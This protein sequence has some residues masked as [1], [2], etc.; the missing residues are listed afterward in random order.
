MCFKIGDKIRLRTIEEMKEA[1]ESKGLWA[2]PSYLNHFGK[3]GVI[4]EDLTY[5]YGKPIYKVKFSE[6]KEAVV[7]SIAWIVPKNRYDPSDE[8]KEALAGKI[9]EGNEIVKDLK[10]ATI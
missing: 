7:I 10:N 3:S 2:D 8:D 1:Y 9:Y 5:I 6:Y 4:T